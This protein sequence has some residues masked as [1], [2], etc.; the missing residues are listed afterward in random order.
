[1]IVSYFMLSRCYIICQKEEGVSNDKI[2]VDLFY[3]IFYFSIN[4]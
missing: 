2:S 4:K 1:M 3:S